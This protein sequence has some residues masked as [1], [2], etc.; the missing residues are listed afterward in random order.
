MTPTKTYTPYTVEFQPGDRFEIKFKDKLI[1]AEG[2]QRDAALIRS[3]VDLLNA[4]FSFGVQDVRDQVDPVL[5]D[6][7]SEIDELKHLVT[8]ANTEMIEATNR[9]FALKASVEA[10]TVQ[11]ETVAPAVLFDVDGESVQQE[12]VEPH[13]DEHTAETVAEYV[14]DITRAVKKDKSTKKK[15]K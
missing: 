8:V 6:Y 10:G 14:N 7:K 2:R 11:A 12:A 9:Y 15:G 5:T 3:T 4:A 1:V 13:I